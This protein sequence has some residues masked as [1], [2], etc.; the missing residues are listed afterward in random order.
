VPI[1]FFLV[2]YART[3]DVSPVLFG[4]AMLLVLSNIV[5]GT[6]IFSL[7]NLWTII[8]VRLV[9]DRVARF[10]FA[11]VLWLVVTVIGIIVLFPVT[12]FVSEYGT[13]GLLFALLGYAVRHKGEAGAPAL[14][15][16]KDFSSWFM[17]A[18]FGI[19]VVLQAAV[20][21]TFSPAQV[22]AMAIG[23]LITTAICVYVPKVTYGSGQGPVPTFLVPVV[24]VLGRYTLEFYVIHLILFKLACLV[25]GLGHPVYAWFQWD[26]TFF[27]T[28]AVLAP[29]IPA[30][31]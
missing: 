29:Q 4:G 14:V 24:K 8:F 21:T 15:Q 1:W 17:L 13:L 6:Y 27:Q 11:R 31:P 10:A 7:N 3:R 22:R 19:A 18:V 23:M 28:Y 5:V 20:F 30:L 9:L 16:K 26:W 2:G 25:L 12:N